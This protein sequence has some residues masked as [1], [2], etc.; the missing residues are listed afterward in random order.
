MPNI[1]IIE[2]ES[3]EG[4]LKEIYDNPDATIL[5]KII[6]SALRQDLKSGKVDVVETKSEEK[7]NKEEIK[8]E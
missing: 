1:N 4:E 2:P 5:E 6:A 3:A 7:E 8:N